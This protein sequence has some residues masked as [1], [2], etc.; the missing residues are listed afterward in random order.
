MIIY[1]KIDIYILKIFIVFILMIP[2]KCITCGKHLSDIELEF[3][4]FRDECVR[5]RFT[6]KES[7]DDLCA[8]KLDQLCIVNRCCRSQCITSVELAKIIM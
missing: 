7:V 3:I 1:K 2:P 5:N 4:L 8:K 6:L